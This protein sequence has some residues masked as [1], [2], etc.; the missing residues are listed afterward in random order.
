M[1]L[2]VEIWLLL[3]IIINYYYYQK[4]KLDQQAVACLANGLRMPRYEIN[5]IYSFK[6]NPSK[7]IAEDKTKKIDTNTKNKK[8]KY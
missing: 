5:Q 6:L 7:N 2:I 8:I 4:L 1:W 3:K